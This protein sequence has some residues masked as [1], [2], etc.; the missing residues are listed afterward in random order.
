VFHEIVL[1][2]SVVAFPLVVR[3]TLPETTWL[4]RIVESFV[5]LFVSKSVSVTLP[6]APKA[7]SF[8][9][10]TVKFLLVSLSVDVKFVA[11]RALTRSENVW[12]R[13]SAVVTIVVF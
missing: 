2:A 8:G 11:L 4:R 12:G 1:P 13:L 10:K 9:A 3:F 5:V 6:S 7:A